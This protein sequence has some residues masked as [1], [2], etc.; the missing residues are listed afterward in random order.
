M[1]NKIIFFVLFVVFLLSILFFS[2]F[3]GK[4]NGEQA[5]LKPYLTINDSR[6]N[7]S[8]ADT[9][10]AQAQGLSYQKSLDEDNGMLFIF[11]EKKN[12][13]FWMKD[14]N[15]PLDIVWISGNTIVKIDKNLPPEGNNPQ[16]N[17]YSGAPV[18][19]VLEVNG[20]FCDKNNIK[21]G[22]EVKYFLN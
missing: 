19:Y 18:D 22:D 13:S 11:S 17:Y 9:P 21:V 1:N 8:I 14:M 6:V 5:F 15:F 20:N 3:F 12:M 7:L 2:I 16:I 4:N 10:P